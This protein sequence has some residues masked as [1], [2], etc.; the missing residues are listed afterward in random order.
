MA[1][2][3]SKY[4]KVY[5]KQII[6][7]MAQGYSI[8]A[9]GGE[10]GVHKDTIYEWVKIYPEFSDA[11]KIGESKSRLFWEKLGILH[12]VNKSDAE[13]WHEGGSKS[14]SRALNA[15]AWIFN[16]K[17]RFGWKDKIED[18][19]A[20]KGPKAIKIAYVPKSQRKSEQE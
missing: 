2:A 8:E 18:D 16:M 5:C 19:E 15:S 3:P 9:C 13:S 11:K 20:L 7:L 14:K 12:I 10:I 6:D 1:G 4:K 17:N